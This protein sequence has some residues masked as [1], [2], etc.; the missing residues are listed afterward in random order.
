MRECLL[1]FSDDPVKK[2]CENIQAFTSTCT[3]MVELLLT[4]PTDCNIQS[5]TH[6]LRAKKIERVDIHCETLFVY[7]FACMSIQMVCPWVNAFDKGRTE[8]HGT[9]FS[10]KSSDEENENSIITVCAI[11]GED[12]RVIVSVL[13]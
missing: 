10:C 13:Q 11:L 6:F 1:G 4:C 12:Q 7:G 8:V 5:V 9:P 3:R 2:L